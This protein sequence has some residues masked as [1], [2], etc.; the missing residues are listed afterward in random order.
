[1]YPI[2]ILKQVCRNLRLVCLY[3][4][5]WRSIWINVLEDRSPGNL[6]FHHGERD[7]GLFPPSPAFTFCIVPGTS[8]VIC[9]AGSI[10]IVEPGI[11]VFFYLGHWSVITIQAAYLIEIRFPQLL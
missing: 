1:M 4:I 3:H 10:S 2:V 6:R 7:H 8:H 11:S 9:D 5:H